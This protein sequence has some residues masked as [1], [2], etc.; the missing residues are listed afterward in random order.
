ELDDKIFNRCNDLLIKIL[1][2]GKQLSRDDINQ[3]FKKVKIIASGHRLSYIMMNAELNGIICSGARQGNKFTYALLDERIKHKKLLEKE[4]ALA[5]LTTRYFK[6][7]GPATIKDFATWSGL[8]MTHCKKG[9]EMMKPFL[10]K[11]AVE[12]QE[13]FFTSNISL[14][15][16]Q[17]ETIHLLPIY[18]EFVMGYK[19]RRAMMLSKSDATFHFDNM[20]LCEGQAIGTWKRTI[21]NKSLRVEYSFFM[22]PN[23][24]Q[25]NTFT[26]SVHR[27]GEFTGM[28]ISFN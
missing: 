4:E 28:H 14:V 16:K 21:R 26:Q 8:T 5:E 19:D 6:S 3:E 27:L 12:G 23:K 18:D 9:I 22:L 10:E 11:A 20:I 7:R 17:F 13:Y 15:D 25:I 24:N 2:G 1:Q